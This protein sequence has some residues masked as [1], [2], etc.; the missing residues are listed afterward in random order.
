MRQH[1]SL[2]GNIAGSEKRFGVAEMRLAL[3]KRGVHHTHHRKGNHP[4][5]QR[6]DYVVT[7]T[8][9]LMHFH[10]SPFPLSL[11]PGR[12]NGVSTPANRWP[13]CGRARHSPRKWDEY[14]IEVQL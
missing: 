8:A 13:G 2:C 11:P 5:A 10:R 4:D 6:V 7:P 14:S 9:D 1:R 3:V 12:Q